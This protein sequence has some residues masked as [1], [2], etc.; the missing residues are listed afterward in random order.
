MAEMGLHIVRLQEC[1]DELESIVAI[2]LRSKLWGEAL[3]QRRLLD[4]A[5]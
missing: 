2:V 4:L 3:G 5:Y 1:D